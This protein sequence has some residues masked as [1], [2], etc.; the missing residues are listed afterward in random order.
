M[1]AD[2]NVLP[3]EVIYDRDT[4]KWGVVTNSGNPCGSRLLKG[5]NPP[6][7]SEWMFYV[8]HEANEL[9]DKLTQHIES[10]WPKKKKKG[11]R[12]GRKR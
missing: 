3:L 9:C 2:H 12:H 7:I 4:E 1:I 6:R 10:E 11:E 5:V 8:E